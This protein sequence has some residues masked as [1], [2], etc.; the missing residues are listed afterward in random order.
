[1]YQDDPSLL[2]PDDD[3]PLWRY[4]DFTK[5]LSILQKRQLFFSRVDRFEDPFEGSYPEPM[6]REAK[7]FKEIP[8]QSQAHFAERMDTHMRAEARKLRTFAFANCWHENRHESAAMW[9]LYLESHEG[10]A[11]RSTFTRL[12]DC[13]SPAS[14]SI[15]IG[16]V[17]YLDYKAERIPENKM[18]AACMHKRLSF[19]HEQEVR[20][21]FIDWAEGREVLA[22]QKAEHSHK[23]VNIPC[24][25][26][27]LIEK[28]YVSPTSDPWFQDLVE[29]AVEKYWKK[30]TVEKSDLARAPIW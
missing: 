27:K 21:V 3:A 8:Q 5:F 12:R 29:D 18:A 23:G 30:T 13:F 22:D 28:I 15:Y 24:D 4:M 20:A 16:K 25:L 9:R 19:A 6:I 7:D 10:I 2:K 26:D 1:V 14:Q 11:V 17:K